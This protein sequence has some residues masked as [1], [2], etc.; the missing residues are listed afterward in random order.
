MVSHSTSNALVSESHPAVLHLLPENNP[1]RLLFND[2]LTFSQRDFPAL[3]RLFYSYMNTGSNS[4]DQIERM[5][6]LWNEI[7]NANSYVSSLIVTNNLFLIQSILY[8]FKGAIDY[9]SEMLSQ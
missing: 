6:L 5:S 7:D 9:M 1:N 8:H 2:I 3:S 4:Y